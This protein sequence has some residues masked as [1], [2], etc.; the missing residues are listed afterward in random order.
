M[1]NKSSPH[2]PQVT[3][4]YSLAWI[5][6]LLHHPF[7]RYHWQ[8]AC[9]DL[10]RHPKN[11]KINIITLSHDKVKRYSSS[12]SYGHYHLDSRSISLLQNSYLKKLCK[13]LCVWFLYLLTKILYWLIFRITFSGSSGLRH[14]TSSWRD[15]KK[16]VILEVS[17]FFHGISDS[18]IL[19]SSCQRHLKFS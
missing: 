11:I 13:C 14:I 7:L 10:S 4:Q 12:F 15:T 1:K 17:I 5:G 18:Q 2:K 19:L 9:D 6:S 3:S 16:F 8:S